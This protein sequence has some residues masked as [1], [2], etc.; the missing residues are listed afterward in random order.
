MYLV[1]LYFDEESTRRIQNLIDKTAFKSGNNFMVE[2]NV[3]PH[4]TIASFQSQ[5]EEEVIKRLDS[6]IKDIEKDKITLASIGVFKSSV[7]FLSP[8][9][10]E[11]LHNLSVNINKEISKIKDVSISRFYL[12]FSWMPHIT[13][14]KKLSR[15][16]LLLGFQEL[17][18]NFS[19]FN[20]EVIKIG[21]S[22]TNPYEEIIK[23]NL[24]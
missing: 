10:N 15:D 21:L 9:L 16:E 13:I 7:L 24:K 19:T 1:S 5:N 8:V 14:A 18:K 3:P 23:W 4:I 20:G 6:V 17:E 22:K 11:Y 2:N 12:P